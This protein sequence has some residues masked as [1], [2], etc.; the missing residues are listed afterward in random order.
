M[1][2]KWSHAR[3]NTKLFAILETVTPY[4]T[5]LNPIYVSTEFFVLT[6]DNDVDVWPHR[7]PHDHQRRL[8]TGGT[9]AQTWPALLAEEAR[10]HA[11]VW[12]RRLRENVHEELPPQSTSPH[13]HRYVNVSRSCLFYIWFW[14][15]WCH[16]QEA[17]SPTLVAIKRS[18]TH[19]FH[20]VFTIP[21][22][23]CT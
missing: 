5:T 9:K 2:L 8:P 11:H 15:K 23:C 12:L 1:C 10:R 7:A 21:H 20:A 22:I 13:A 19:F 14:I 17:G 3:Q 16:L 6:C 4:N 18:L